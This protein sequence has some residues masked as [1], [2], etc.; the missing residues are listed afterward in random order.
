VS[1]LKFIQILFLSQSLVIVLFGCQKNVNQSRPLYIE[2][3][4][5]LDA[6]GNSYETVIIG[7]QEWMAENLRTSLFC[8][9]DSIPAT[10]DTVQVKVYDN[11]PQNE[12]IFGKLYNYVAV[13]NPAGLCPCGWRI[14][15]ELDFARLINYLGGYK[16]AMKKMKASGTLES[17]TGLWGHDETRKDLFGTN[18]SGFNA[19]PAGRGFGNSFR[20]K[21]SLSVFWATPEAGNN[22]LMYQIFNP[23]IEKQM[24]SHPNA[25]ISLYY[26]VRCIKEFP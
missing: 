26:S 16:D 17:G 8:S 14:P 9:G 6:E 12:A 2:G 24:Y 25:K 7:D 19:L 20:Y 23:Y 15:T 21:D 4:G 1:A 18:S 22:A 11:D 5:V 13:L 10:G 3:N